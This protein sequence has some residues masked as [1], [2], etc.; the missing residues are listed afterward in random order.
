MLSNCQ[1]LAFLAQ[2]LRSR[3]RQTAGWPNAI[4]RC[5]NPA[6]EFGDLGFGNDQGRC[7]HEAACQRP[8]D[9]AFLKPGFV[10]L[11]C[12][13]ANLEAC[14]G[15]R[16]AFAGIGNLDGTSQAPLSVSHDE[17]VIEQA[18]HHAVPVRDHPGHMSEHVTLIKDVQDFE[19]ETAAETTWAWWVAPWANQPFASLP[20]SIRRLNS[21]P[22]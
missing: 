11:L 8:D 19:V 3:S 15:S 18:V 16:T 14:G 13:A 22:I 21:S 5:A 17:R 6:A 12:G 20:R 9:D 4:E 1:E 7:H 2:R 10:D